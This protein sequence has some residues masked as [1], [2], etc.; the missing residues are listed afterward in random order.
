MALTSHNIKSGWNASGLWPRNAS[1]P[2]MSRLLLE[3]SN[4]SLES[5]LADLNKE[6]G[7]ISSELI[8][9]VTW[10][11]PR[12]SKDLRFQSQIATQSK[13]LDLPTRRQLFRKIAK[14][15]DEKDYALAQSNLRIQ[16][17]E[18]RLEELAPRKRHKVRTSPNSRFA[19]IKAIKQAQIEAGDRQIEE[20]DS[21]SEVESVATSDCIELLPL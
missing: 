16:Q 13:E 6:E 1:K 10:S 12:A 15:F 2:L 9:S 8:S 17:L 21:E 7:P 19:D 3:N 5:E 18:T 4:Q 14:G 11:T 20:E